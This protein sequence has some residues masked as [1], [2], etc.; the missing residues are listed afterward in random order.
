MKCS[1]CEYNKGCNAIL[2]TSVKI[3]LTKCRQ[4]RKVKTLKV[5]NVAPTGVN[6][7]V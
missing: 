7:T 1:E 2:K 4:G 5:K 3:G 6:N